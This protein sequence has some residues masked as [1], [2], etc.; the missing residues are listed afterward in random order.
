MK[1]LQEGEEE[2]ATPITARP[3]TEVEVE[4]VVIMAAVEEEAAAMEEADQE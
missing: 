2:E 4:V 1:S 3:D